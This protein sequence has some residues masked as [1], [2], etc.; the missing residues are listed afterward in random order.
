MLP[1]DLS[2]VI[3]PSLQ[4]ITYFC[5]VSKMSSERVRYFAYSDAATFAPCRLA[6]MDRL[7]TLALAALLLSCESANK[8]ELAPAATTPATPKTGTTAE[9]VVPA[10]PTPRAEAPSAKLVANS[11]CA[12]ICSRSTELG[13]SQASTCEATC[14]ASMADGLCIAEMSAAT[15]CML[16]EPAKNWECSEEGLS[17]IKDGF[18]ED[19]QMQVVDCMMAQP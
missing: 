6:V 14:R 18:C 5:R 19:E 16:R 9:P 10:E 11:P 13:C 4:L 1:H 12:A 17:A 8:G 2:I 7:T 3:S 15:S